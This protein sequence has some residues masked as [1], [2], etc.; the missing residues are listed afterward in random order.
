[1]KT[2]T[3]ILLLILALA[4]SVLAVSVVA[5]VARGGDDGEVSYREVTADEWRAAF[6]FDNARNQ[7]PHQIVLTHKE[8]LFLQVLR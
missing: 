8:V 3:K 4:L 7:F 6:K 2:L 1:M 5:L